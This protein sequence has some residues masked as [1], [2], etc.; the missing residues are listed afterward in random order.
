M[1]RLN[2]TRCVDAHR[3]SFV[4]FSK[5]AGSFSVRVAEGERNGPVTTNEADSAVQQSAKHTSLA[6]FLNRQQQK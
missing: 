1:G 6:E 3:N 5:G 2:L 4:V